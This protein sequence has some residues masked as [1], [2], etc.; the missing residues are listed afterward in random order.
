MYGIKEFHK[1]F[2]F[3][4][5]AASVIFLAVLAALAILVATRIN[6]DDL[7]LGFAV[8]DG[9][10]KLVRNTAIAMTVFAL[11]GLLGFGF[12]AIKHFYPKGK[13]S[14][15]RHGS[16]LTLGYLILLGTAL[17]VAI[18]TWII[19]AIFYRNSTDGKKI[20]A[21]II[22]IAVLSGVLFGGV[23]TYFVI[24]YFMMRHSMEHMMDGKKSPRKKSPTKRKS[25]A[26]R[27]GRPRSV[28]KKKK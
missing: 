13:M 26:K 3:L 11:A 19:L 8:A 6:K 21:F 9:D 16:S 22:S 10:K 25:P 15:M 14:S 20:Q 5:V 17:A 7:C 27:R 18:C 2:L 24:Y 28:L 4:L 1:D 12:L 23:V